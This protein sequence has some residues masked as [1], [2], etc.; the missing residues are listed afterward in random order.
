MK[1]ITGKDRNQTYIFPTFLELL[2]FLY[3]LI[4]SLKTACL[5]LYEQFRRFLQIFT[6]SEEKLENNYKFAFI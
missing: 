6:E 2:V 4:E 1:Y 3:F 5:S